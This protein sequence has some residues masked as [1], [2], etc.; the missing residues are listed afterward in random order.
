MVGAMECLLV[1]MAQFKTEWA[2][3]ST[4]VKIIVSKIFILEPEI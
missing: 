1:P 4:G 2:S 3:T